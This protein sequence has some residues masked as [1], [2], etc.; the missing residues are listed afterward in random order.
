MH[1]VGTPSLHHR[2]A[3]FADQ[4]LTLYREAII[5]TK[6]GWEVTDDVKLLETLTKSHKL[7]YDPVGVDGLKPLT[8]KANDTEDR[9]NVKELLAYMQHPNKYCCN[10]KKTAQERVKEYK[11]GPKKLNCSYLK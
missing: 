3:L 6:L 10:Q 4:S 1:K 11:K 8:A 9:F 5:I 7:T 2:Y